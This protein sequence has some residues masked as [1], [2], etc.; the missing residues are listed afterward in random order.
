[1]ATS[2]PPKSPEAAFLSSPSGRRKYQQSQEHPN[3]YTSPLKRSVKTPNLQRTPHP[4]FGKDEDIGLEDMD[5]DED[6]E[7][8]QLKLAA[9]EAKLKLKKLQQSKAK[10]QEEP[11]ETKV[12]QSK[13]QPHLSRKTL[14]SG[15]H[16]KGGQDPMAR[17]RESA[18]EVPISPTK[19]SKLSTEQ[20]SPSRVL[21]GI[22]KG[23]RGDDVSLGRARTARDG[24][25]LRAAS[26]LDRSSSRYS[27]S[28]S[29]R[30]TTSST[31]AAGGH[32]KSFSE[33]MAESR[34]AEKSKEDQREALIK[35]RSTGFKLNRAE[36][37]SLR[38]AAEEARSHSPP[39][40]VKHR[41]GVEFRREEILRSYGEQKPA[42]S[43][44][45][46]S[47]TAPT[48]QNSSRKPAPSSDDDG[49]NTQQKN[50][51]SR[52]T[53]LF[54]GFSQLQLST[55]ILPH[56]FLQRTL[57]DESYTSLRLPDLLKNVHAPLYELPES[58][59]DYVVFGIIASKSSPQDHKAGTGNAN[60]A[61][62]AKGSN[63]WEKQWEDGSQNQKKFMVF[64]LTD[65]T[66]SVDLF[67]FGTALP[68]YHR[69]SLGT[70]VAI[71]NPGVMPPKK[72]REDT[73]AFS[74]TLHSGDDTVLEIGT[75]RDLGFCKAIKKDGKECGSWINSAKTEYC[76]WHLNAQVS[77]AQ[78][79]R[80]GVNTGSNASGLGGGGGT[81]ARNRFSSGRVTG[82]GRE[83]KERQPLLPRKGGQR[84]DSHTGSHYFIASSGAASNSGAV[85]TP[86]Y[87]PDR[88]AANLLDMVDDDPFTADGQLSRDNG[89][90]L[91][92]RLVAEEKE[93]CI[94]RN[95][96]QMNSGGAGGDY[97]RQRLGVDGSSTGQ[98]GSQ[99]SALAMKVGIMNSDPSGKGNGK[100]SAESVRLSPIKKTR[101]LTEN[102][103]RH[104][105]RESL[106]AKNGLGHT[107][108]GDD[109]DI[110]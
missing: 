64:Q 33:K 42:S 80:M 96:A 83:A 6:E 103:I 17:F 15:L 9:I 92:K 40:S 45:K 36:M 13:S 76:E 44:L 108:D 47:K 3:T 8:L 104:P 89:S 75:A 78:A 10:S 62:S 69:L 91:R 60:S 26:I 102:G 70:V 54:E 84:F 72:G 29:V 73:G 25:F 58:V 2:W 109:L 87:H 105:G 34:S 110:V 22:D 7:T 46:R 48:I 98:P 100:R 85:G 90:R 65:L 57:P 94:A 41:E 19:K 56:T 61:G 35:R 88:S 38:L 12:F 5:E 101:L 63:D 59:V 18:V 30:T 16:G 95:L 99:R 51:Q 79:G 52:D 106:G 81:E 55:R 11:S 77:K 107:D 49:G 86:A 43:Q 32:F 93:R 67:L 23:I 50:R 1:M 82:R 14:A 4:L 66:W 71:L 20:R 28:S 24:T 74:L 68:R 31:T 53:S 27:A 21:L 37:E 39:R 97:I